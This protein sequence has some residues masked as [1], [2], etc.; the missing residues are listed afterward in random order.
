PGTPTPTEQSVRVD[1][2]LLEKLMNLVG[3]LVLARNQLQQYTART[4]DGALSQMYQRIDL[5]TSELQEGMMKTRMQ[6]VGTVWS[7]LPRVVRDVASVCG[8]TVRLEMEG[9]DTEVDRAL[10]DAIRDPLTHIVRNSV[11]HGIELPHD[12]LAAGK[13][14]EGT[15]RVRAWHEGGQ[16]NI[17]IADDGRGIAVEKV[18]RKAIERGLVTPEEGAKLT[19]REVV[20]LI[21]LPGFSTA[22]QVTNVSGRGV[23]MDVVRTDIGAVNG[24]VDVS[25]VTGQGMALRIRLPL[26]LAII[27][28]LIAHSGAEQFAIPQVNV[29]QLVRFDEGKAP[30]EHVHD[31][32]LFR[33]RDE[34]LPLMMLDEELGLSYGGEPSPDSEIIVLQAGDRRFGLVVDRVGDSAEIVVKPLARALKPLGAFSGATITGDGRVALILDVPGL[35]RRAR[36]AI[37]AHEAAGSAVAGVVEQEVAA[38]RLLIVQTP[39]DGR[40]AIPLDGISR[41]EEIPAPHVEKVGGGEVVRYRG[42]V[43]PLAR[44]SKVLVEKRIRPRRT[45]LMPPKLEVL[46]T[47]VHAGSRGPVGI[48]VDKVLDIVEV[49]IDHRRP[50]VRPGVLY[51]AVIHGRVTEV[52]DM[53]WVVAKASPAGE[54]SDA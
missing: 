28:A 22:D 14:V 33:H 39:D 53:A 30:V 49:T 51:S 1:V 34:L 19:D 50:A 7:K 10:L 26:T 8:K 4:N 38:L 43:L 36:L 3:E 18:R 12:R 31:A 54:S 13:S 52:L 25:S 41:I 16:V 2:G 9:Q 5:I 35:A 21:F 17:E 46:P 45:T 29:V 23:G 48:V 37:G 11:D 47:V 24:T 42:D 6:T 40:A 20:D 32:R 27:P 15:V 44:L